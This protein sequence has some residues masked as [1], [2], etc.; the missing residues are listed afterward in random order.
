MAGVLKNITPKM[1]SKQI[2]EVLGQGEGI[3][4]LPKQQN[5]ASTVRK[6]SRQGYP[7]SLS[8]LKE[9]QKKRSLGTK[10]RGPVGRMGTTTASSRKKKGGKVGKAKTPKDPN[11]KADLSA[12]G[13][14]NIQTGGVADAYVA[15]ASNSKTE[16]T[17]YGS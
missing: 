13:D 14:V 10:S 16:K 5:I 2:S 6:L 9:A 8:K 12:L 1:T 15:N 11:Q 17:A 3:P 4:K 7:S